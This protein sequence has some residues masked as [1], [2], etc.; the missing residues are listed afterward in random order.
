MLQL[1]VKSAISKFEKATNLV[2][3]AEMFSRN[4]GVEE[5]PT[6]TLRYL[7]LPALLGT[8]TLK[9]CNQP[10]IDLVNVAD[11]YYKLVT[12]FHYS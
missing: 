6:E 3:L 1:S 9:L 10:R 5:L 2:S 11:I 12:L 8:L 4:E 7:L